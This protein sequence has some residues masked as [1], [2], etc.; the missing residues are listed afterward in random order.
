MIEGYVVHANEPGG[1]AAFLG[2]LS[3]WHHIFKDVVYATQEIM[4][5]AVA[6]SPCRPSFDSV[7]NRVLPD[8]QNLGRLGP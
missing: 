5:D 6:V 8:L 3:T 7:F 1:P 2:V 4:G